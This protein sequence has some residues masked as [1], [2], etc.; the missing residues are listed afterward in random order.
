VP[1]VPMFPD[2]FPSQELQ[3]LVIVN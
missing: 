2:S 3:D 1:K